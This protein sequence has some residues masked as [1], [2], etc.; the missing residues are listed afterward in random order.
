[1][2]DRP[3]SAGDPLP[4]KCRIIE[5]RVGELRQLFNAIDPSPFRERDL[6]PAAEDF[7]VSWGRGLPTDAPLGLVVHVDRAAGL[8]DEAAIL[9]DAIHEFFR[10]RAAATLMNLADLFRRGRISLAIGLACLAA[11]IGTGD[12]LV[13]YFPSSRLA[14]ILRESLL[15]GGWV[16]MWRP[17]EIF[18][19][20]WWPIRAEAR[21]CNRLS[22][23]PVRIIYA[24][25]DA[26]DAWRRDWPAVP[27]CDPPRRS[28]T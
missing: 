5:V 12:I 4:P 2:S 22:A 25:T 20:D 16:A 3:P 15:I 21:L 23:M 1:M 19:Y 28:G 18:L 24:D 27:A 26:T 14:T 10:Q 7:I 9:R 8:P 13:N 11:C 17:L 6:D